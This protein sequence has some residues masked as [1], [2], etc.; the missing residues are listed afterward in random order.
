M[1]FPFIFSSIIRD[2]LTNTSVA[3]KIKLK[4]KGNRKIMLYY[5]N[6]NNGNNIT[7]HRFIRFPYKA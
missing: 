1:L 6:D 4:G 3:N 2:K 7:L 5:N